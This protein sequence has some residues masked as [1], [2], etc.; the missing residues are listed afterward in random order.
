MGGGIF[1]A[2]PDPATRVSLAAV[3]RGNVALISRYR[4]QVRTLPIDLEAEHT[5]VIVEA[6][7]DVLHVKDG[8][9]SLK[10]TRN[11]F[12]GN[13]VMEVAGP[14]RGELGC[15][16]RGLFCKW[17]RSPALGSLDVSGIVLVRF[18]EQGDVGMI[19]TRMVVCLLC[20][21]GSAAEGQSSGASPHGNERLLVALENAWNQAQL[22]HDS[23]ALEEL[24]AETFVSTDNDGVFLTK[25]EFLAD[26]KDLSYAPSLMANS[27]EKIFLYENVAVVA[28]T[29]HAKG[30]YKGKPFDHYGRFTD[31]WVFMNGRWLCVASHTS[32]LNK[33]R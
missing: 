3:A 27:D 23:K 21:A 11:G 10:T 30:L 19:K 26:N 4:R 1:D 17:G 25:A 7:R 9:N 6:G 18:L 24:L 20:L 28:G 8:S 15:P 29:Y 5:N 16:T 12:A 31:T 2:D 14:Q 32:A 22:H 13:E 33:K